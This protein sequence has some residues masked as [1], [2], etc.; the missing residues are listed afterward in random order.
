MCLHSHGFPEVV[1]NP[2][3]VFFLLLGPNWISG[4]EVSQEVVFCGDVLD[5]KI[6]PVGRDDDVADLV[7]DFINGFG[8]IN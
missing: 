2:G 1:H 3:S 7:T 4:E 5:G 6:I 8:V